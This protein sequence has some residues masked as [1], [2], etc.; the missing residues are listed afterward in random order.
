[1]GKSENEETIWNSRWEDDVEMSV[2]ISGVVHWRWSGCWKAGH[3]M[4]SCTMEVVTC[5]TLKCMYCI[6]LNEM[7]RC[8]RIFSISKEATVRAP[9][10][11]PGIRLRK[12][13]G[14]CLI[15]GSMARFERDG[16]RI[17]ILNKPFHQPSL[18]TVTE[19]FTIICDLWLVEMH[20]Y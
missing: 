5:L 19:I 14:T 6:A 2:W 3:F 10:C 16:S 20:F 11:Y 9:L 1:M 12:C 17:Q 13:T 15:A 18:P 8:W 4:S 7:G